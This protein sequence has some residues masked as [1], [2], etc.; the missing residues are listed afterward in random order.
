MMTG[1]SVSGLRVD[2]LINSISICIVIRNIYTVRGRNVARGSS[3]SVEATPPNDE[4]SFS[5][6]IAQQWLQ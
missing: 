3:A 2:Q 5:C 4:A 1:G 6:S